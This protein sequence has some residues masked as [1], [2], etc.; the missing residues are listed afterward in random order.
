MDKFQ[1]QEG[2]D[3]PLLSDNDELGSVQ[4]MQVLAMPV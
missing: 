3:S 2:P 4:S 1:S